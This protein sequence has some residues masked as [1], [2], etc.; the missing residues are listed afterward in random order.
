MKELKTL[1]NLIDFVGHPAVNELYTTQKRFD[2]LDR[3]LYK[4]NKLKDK[5]IISHVP[6]LNKNQLEYSTW[7]ERLIEVKEKVVKKYNA[8][9]IDMI[10]STDVIEV[11]QLLHKNN[12]I[13]KPGLTQIIFGGTNLSG[14]ILNK[15]EVSVKSFVDLG[16]DCTIYLPMCTECD[17]VGVNDLEKTWIAINKIYD[18]VVKNNITHKVSLISEE[19]DLMLK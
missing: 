18:Y 1:I 10:E 17:Q 15:K 3:L 11:T 7:A 8:T 5:V 4:N 9:W 6:N 12:Y 13:I 2:T 19:R 16:F 14:C